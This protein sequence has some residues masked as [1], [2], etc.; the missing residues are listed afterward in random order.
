MSDATISKDTKLRYLQ[1]FHPQAGSR[2]FVVRQGLRWHVKCGSG[3][4]SLGRF[5]R[6]KAALQTAAELNTAFEDGMYV[7]TQYRKGGGR[8]A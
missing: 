8:Y 5:F 1:Q 6:N 2:Y 7:V 4:R 3:T